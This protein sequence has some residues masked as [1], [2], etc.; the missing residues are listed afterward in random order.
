M[1]DDL[2]APRV[3]AVDD[4]AEAA[5]RS[6]D[7]TG[8]GE[9]GVCDCLGDRDVADRSVQLVRDRD[10]TAC[11]D[12]VQERLR[13]VDRGHESI[14]YLRGGSVRR[15]VNDHVG[16]GYTVRNQIEFV[17]LRRVN[18]VRDRDGLAVY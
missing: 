7:H 16:S 2:A 1:L 10:R 13:G 5:S 14:A 18:A 6:T 9:A 4:L 12:R 11:V 3:V 8:H 15:H 17:D